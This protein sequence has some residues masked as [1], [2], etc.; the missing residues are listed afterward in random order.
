MKYKTPMRTRNEFP[1][2]LNELQLFGSAIE[3]GVAEGYFSHGLLDS[4]PGIC[5][6]VDP[7]K[8]LQTPGFSP[9][10]E[11]TDA[12]QEARYQRMLNK[13]KEYRGRC[14]VMRS[15]SEDAVITFVR[16][17]FDFVYIDAIHTYEANKQDLSLWW[18]K[19]KP[20][21]VFAGH[22]YLNGTFHGQLYGV[23]TAVDEFAKEK[24]LTVHST[25]D[26]QW[27]SWFIF[28]P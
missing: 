7:W 18:P 3:V 25:P 26:D 20:G 21:G 15:T 13:A 22:D 11:A 9:H 17:F 16:D 6:Q 24:G 14:Q 1:R 19:V 23:K 8:I 10:G 12:D 2:L 4:W 28:K 5:W 27:P